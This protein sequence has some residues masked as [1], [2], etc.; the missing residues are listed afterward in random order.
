MS[1]AIFKTVEGGA[2]K[3]NWTWT[4]RAPGWCSC[5]LPCWWGPSFRTLCCG[6]FANR[7]PRKVPVQEH[8]TK[9]FSMKTTS[10]LAF[11][12]FLCIPFAGCSIEESGAPAT[13][14]DGVAV[15]K[16][17]SERDA[18]EGPDRDTAPPAAASKGPCFLGVPKKI[19][20]SF[21]PA[22][23]HENLIRIVLADEESIST[24]RTMDGSDHPRQDP[25]VLPKRP[26]NGHPLALELLAPE[27]A[28]LDDKAWVAV[29][30]ELEHGS[31]RGLRLARK[32][33]IAILAHSR[34]V[35]TSQSQF[36]TPQKI[37]SELTAKPPFLLTHLSQFRNGL[38]SFRGRP[39]E[40]RTRQVLC[41]QAL[42]KSP[43]E[44]IVTKRVPFGEVGDKRESLD[45]FRDHRDFLGRIFRPG[46][47]SRDRQSARRGSGRGGG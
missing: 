27:V 14:E 5:R 1:P 29:Q 12:V 25:V 36:R 18:A 22:P 38:L 8:R 41:W 13:Q 40:T 23:V 47:V 20:C 42:T 21:G 35:L 43:K 28:G 46:Y 11:S 15:N 26:S 32:P 34:F 19:W 24:V 3:A 45:A 7:G 31:K 37:V 39:K 30:Q 44:S 10:T 4:T 17:T 6:P 9:G 2:F 16:D 33:P